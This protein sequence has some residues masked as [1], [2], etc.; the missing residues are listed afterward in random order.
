M[1]VSVHSFLPP[2]ASRPR[3]IGTY[4]TCSLEKNLI[5][6][7][8]TLFRSYI[9]CHLLAS[10]ATLTTPETQNTDTNGIH[11]TKNVSFRSYST[12]SYLVCAH[13][14]N[15]NMRMY[16]TSVCGHELSGRCSCR[17]A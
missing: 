9:Q 12:F 6:A 4:V 1:C 7:K 15:I 5:F 14:R 16:I 11:A 8:N 10:N 3:N 2:R 17:R 13:N